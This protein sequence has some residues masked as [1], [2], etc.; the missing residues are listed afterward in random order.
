MKK[1][2]YFGTTS[3][4]VRIAITLHD[5]AMLLVGSSETRVFQPVLSACASFVVPGSAGNEGSNCF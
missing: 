3:D 5:A 4:T 1:I 2:S